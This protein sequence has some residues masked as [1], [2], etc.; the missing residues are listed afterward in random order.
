MPHHFT[1]IKVLKLS[2]RV[3]PKSSKNPLASGFFLLDRELHFKQRRLPSIYFLNKFP[4][5]CSMEKHLPISEQF[6]DALIQSHVEN[7][8]AG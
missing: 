5:L 8:F 7:P 2:F 3:V 1:K 6:F 4:Y